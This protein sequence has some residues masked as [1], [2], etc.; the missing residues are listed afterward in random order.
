M[1]ELAG[2]KLP[3]VHT[4]DTPLAHALPLGQVVHPAA[5]EVLPPLVP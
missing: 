5:C 3:L 2:Q 4:T 1:L